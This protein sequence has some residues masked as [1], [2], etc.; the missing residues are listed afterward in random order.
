MQYA[1][2]TCLICCGDTHHD[3]N[4][5]LSEDLKSLSDGLLTVRCLLM[6]KNPV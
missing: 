1:D 5:M 4:R 3:V 6:I 2:D